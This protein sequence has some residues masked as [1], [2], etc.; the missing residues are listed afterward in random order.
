[1]T[2]IINLFG[3]PGCGKSTTAAGLFY[4]M[5]TA[6]YNV[7]LVT[8]YAKDVTWD[9]NFKLLENQLYIFAKQ[10][11]RV[12][13]LKDKVDW[14]ITD[15][16]LLLSEVYLRR[17]DVSPFHEELSRIFIAGAGEL[18]SINIV[19][20]RLKPYVAIGR[21]QTLAQSQ[22]LDLEIIN[23]LNEFGIA[24]KEIGGDEEAPRKII[25]LLEEE[26]CMS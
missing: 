5:K 7:E 2:R 21:T 25:A 1:M 6:G 10:Y 26:L 15:S 11:K 19:L 12:I 16:P 24:F 14:V 9:E 8:E 22:Q 20:E 4:L 17:G 13:R 18:P 3:G 23:V